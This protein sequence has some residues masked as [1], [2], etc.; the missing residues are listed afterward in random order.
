[1]LTKI[2][3]ALFRILPLLEDELVEARRAWEVA[4]E[5]SY[6]LFDTIVSTEHL[7]EVSEGEH[8]E[9]LTLL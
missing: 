3:K 5:D 4:V 6:T 7:W 9:E 8:F 1:L 2:A